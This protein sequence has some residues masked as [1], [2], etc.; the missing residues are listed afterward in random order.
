MDRSA[1]AIR[2]L[3]VE[4]LAE[5]TDAFV[6]HFTAL[7]NDKLPAEVANLYGSFAEDVLPYVTEFLSEV[8]KRM[9]LT[10]ASLAPLYYSEP[11]RFQWKMID[12]LVE[13]SAIVKKEM[14]GKNRWKIG[15]YDVDEDIAKVK[16]QME[17]SMASEYKTE[18]LFFKLWDEKKLDEALSVVRTIEK[19]RE[20][21]TDPVLKNEV[22]GWKQILCAELGYTDLVLKSIQ[23]CLNEFKDEGVHYK[24]DGARHVFSVL[25][26]SMIVGHFGFVF[27]EDG[28][29]KAG[30]LI[31]GSAFQLQQATEFAELLVDKIVDGVLVTRTITSESQLKRFLETNRMQFVNS[32]KLINRY[33]DDIQYTTED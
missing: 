23:Y 30:E 21:S 26:R 24:K 11:T 9:P 20:D 19:E 31:D 2:E 33:V 14:E 4:L 15:N 22:Q 25:L 13:Q 18:I 10:I 28:R 7:F 16:K 5:R 29:K 17:D 6:D 12:A 3:S 32:F 8:V 27:N 1:T